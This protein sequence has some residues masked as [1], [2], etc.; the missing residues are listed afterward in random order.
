M[1]NHAKGYELASWK[2]C[3][4]A[5]GCCTNGYGRVVCIPLDTD[6]RIFIPTPRNSLTWQRRYRGRSA[7]ERLNAHLDRSFGFE[8]HQIRG[9]GR[10]KTRI[11]LALAVMMTMSLASVEERQPRLMRSRA[12]AGSPPDTG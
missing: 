2:D 10:M 3:E 12:R 8:H 7:P 5:G 9:L 1:T 11:T 4:A 6:R